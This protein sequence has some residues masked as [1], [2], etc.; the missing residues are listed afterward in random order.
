MKGP[1]LRLVMLEILSK[2]AVLRGEVFCLQEEA[3]AERKICF[4]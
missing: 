2:Q 3:P 1:Q 4:L